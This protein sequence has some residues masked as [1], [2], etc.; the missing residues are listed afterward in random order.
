M[1]DG[2]NQRRDGTNVYK[3]K[4]ASVGLKCCETKWTDDAVRCWKDEERQKQSSHIIVLDV[5]AGDEAAGG[6]DSMWLFGSKRS[7]VKGTIYVF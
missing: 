6:S 2:K 7:D 1:P 3:Y 5:R 4:T